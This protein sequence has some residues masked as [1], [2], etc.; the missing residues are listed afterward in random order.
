[1]SDTH[2]EGSESSLDFTALFSSAPTTQTDPTEVFTAFPDTTMTTSTCSAA[3]SSVNAS[4]F[5]FFNSEGAVMNLA[6]THSQATAPMAHVPANVCPVYTSKSDPYFLPTGLPIT[7]TCN[8]NVVQQ[9]QIG[10]NV[11]SSATNIFH[12]SYTKSMYEMSS[13]RRLPFAMSNNFHGSVPQNYSTSIMSTSAIPTTHSYVYAHP[14]PPYSTFLLNSNRPISSQIPSSAPPTNFS[15]INFSNNNNYTT[16]QNNNNS[17]YNNTFS[18]NSNFNVELSPSQ[19][20]SRHVISKDLPVFTGRPEEWP[21]FITNFMQSTE[22]CGFSDQENLI[23]LQRALKGP[24]LDAVRGKLMLPS[25]V[26]SAI[27]TLQMLFGRPDVIHHTLQGSLREHPNVK[28]DDLN[29]LISFSLAVQN[30][31]STIQAIGLTDYAFDPV[32]L[33]DLIKK[34]PA[35]MKLDWGKNCINFARPDLFK[36]DKWLFN[37]ATCASQVTTSNI[38]EHKNDEKR[39][40]S[41]KHSKERVYVHDLMQ[42]ANEVSKTKDENNFI[43][44]KCNGKHKLSNCPEFILLNCNDRW[45]LIKDKKLCIKCF[46]KHLMKNCFSKRLCAVDGCKYPHNTLLHNASKST[47]E[48]N[49]VLFHA[50]NNKKTIFRYVPVTVYNNKKAVNTFALIDEGAG[51]TLIETD[52]ATDL[53]LDGPTADLCLRWT[54]DVTQTEQNSKIVSLYVSARDDACQKYNLRNVRTIQ[55]LDLPVQ[56]VEMSAITNRKFLK[57]L[58]IMPYSF[59]KARL[60]IGLDNAKIGAPLDI[61]EDVNDDLMAARCRLGWAVFGRKEVNEFE[62]NRLFHICDC[63]LKINIE[64]Q[65]DAL[66]KEYFSLDSVGISHT[67]KPLMSKEDERALNIMKNTTKYLPNEKRWQTGLLWKFDKINL[68]DSLP[69][70]KRRLKCLETKMMKEPSLKRFLVDKISEYEAKGYVRKLKP[71]EISSSG[72][73]WYIPIF[74]VTNMNKNKTRLVWDAAA[75]VNDTSLNSFLLK[76]PDLLKSLSGILLRFRQKPVAICGDIREMFHQVRVNPEDQGAQMFLWRNGDATREMETYCMQVMTFGAS[77]SPSLA[78]YVKNTNAMRFSDKFP[79][80][81]DSILQNT[82]VDDWLQSTASEAKMISM[83]KHVYEIHMSGGFEMRNW[84]SN[85]DKVLQALSGGRQDDKCFKEPQSTQEKVLGMW[86]Q[87]STDTFTFVQKFSD[88]LFDISIVPTK[89]H[90]LRVVMTIFDP[91]GLLGNYIV[92]AKIIL[93]DIWRSGVSWDQK[94]CKEQHEKWCKWVTCLRL[95]NKFSIPRCHPQLK[96]LT[97]T[98][99]HVFVDASL[100][101]YAAVAYLRF[102]N[103]TDTKCCLISSKTR[104]A[105][106]KPISVP[107]MELMAAIIG[108]RLAKFIENELTIQID[109]RTFWSDSKDVLFW[110]RSDARKFKQFVAVRVGEILEGSNIDEWRWVPSAENVADEATKWSKN[111]NFDPAQRWFVGPDFLS[112]NEEFWPVTT[113]VTSTDN[114]PEFVGHIELKKVYVSQFAAICPEPTRFSKWENLRRTLQFVLKFLKLTGHNAFKSEA[115]KTLMNADHLARIE[116]ILVRVSQEES[117]GEELS[118][119]Q[120]S[121]QISR[122]SEIFKCTPYVDEFGVLRVRGRIDAMLDVTMDQ[123][124]PIILHRKHYIT[125]LIADYYHRRYHHHH[126]EIVVNEMRQRYWIYGLRSLVRTIGKNCQICKNRRAMPCPPEMAALPPERL[127]AYTRPFTF[128]GVDYFGPLEIVVGRRREKRWGVLFTCMTVRAIHVEIAASLSSDSFILALKQFIARRGCP[129]KIMSDNGTNFR[130]ASRILIEEIQKLSCGEIQSKFPEIE[131]QFIPPASPHMG[132]SWERMVRSVKSIL[133]DLVS[134]TG[135]REE[136]LRGALADV[137]NIINSRP[138]TYL[139]LDSLEDE[140]LTPN[141]LLLG[142][143]SGIREK[144]NVC[145]TD[146]RKNYKIAG[147]LADRFWKRWIKEYLPCLTRRSKWFVQSSC[148][149]EVGDVVIIVDEASKRGSWPKGRVVDIHRSKDNQ[150]RSAVIQTAKGLITRPAVKLAK[151]DVR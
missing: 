51:C 6:Y 117:F 73:S 23:R 8:S 150:V 43:C 145:E 13:S 21:L 147:Q 135:L 48:E 97:T 115:L 36:F 12:P 148:G 22:R 114:S 57:E 92:Q 10:T 112:K 59:A 35:T 129:A 141:H 85:S 50:K 121:T 130:G 143:S 72:K 37:L 25:T 47:G 74:T 40:L 86:W 61:V 2:E 79:L 58:P 91:I 104:I 28:T 107:R 102:S 75:T 78:N 31:C 137:E 19:I 122:K 63:A 46:G 15:N 139:P 126:N 109:S 26:G 3:S 110:I 18:Y 98:Q 77:C 94:I 33:K 32:L 100:N 90:V 118:C 70:A 5:T 84:I 34:L 113:F 125:F 38:F 136:V 4:D 103:A 146:L 14:T 68:P 27:E 123:K 24:A 89:R 119:L 111:I 134:E 95:I 132:G 65:M 101:A 106:L 131:W 29:T 144:G 54:G 64:K 140:A 81:V 16:F 128:T 52:L 53:G 120:N 30:Y 116:D 149:I 108:L 93:Q 83:A 66:M 56:T 49:N 133:M 7:S 41:V 20:A 42:N 88:E 39:N 1:M 127:A 142:T 11:N 80:E 99:L 138:L 60:L 96:E 69:M 55:S 67:I 76:G 71:H 105:P 45:K 9:C 17:P 151:L 44:P 82:F 124:R 87:P 62:P